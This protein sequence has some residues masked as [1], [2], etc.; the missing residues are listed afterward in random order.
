MK[1]HR[2]HELNANLVELRVGRLVRARRIH[3]HVH[4]SLSG[5]GG[6]QSDR[7]QFHQLGLDLWVQVN[8]LHKASSES[9]PEKS[10]W[11][12]ESI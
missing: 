8:D 1:G 10:S 9:T 3:D 5:H 7:K 12:L 6:T 4:G 11:E 2:R